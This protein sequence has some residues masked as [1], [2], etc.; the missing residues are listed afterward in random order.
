MRFEHFADIGI[1]P[2]LFDAAEDAELLIIHGRTVG[3][4]YAKRIRS[5]CGDCRFDWPHGDGVAIGEQ[6]V[7]YESGTIGILAGLNE[8]QGLAGVAC[9]HCF[10]QGH[11]IGRPQASARWQ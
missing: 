7:A 2:L 6:P 4:Q 5:L 10:R 3:E 9:C 8:A 1:V 11:L